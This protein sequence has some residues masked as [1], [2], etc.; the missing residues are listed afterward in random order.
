MKE[1]YIEYII[2]NLH[3]HIISYSAF[4][5]VTCSGKFRTNNANFI[6]R[7]THYPRPCWQHAQNSSNA[8]YVCRLPCPNNFTVLN[9]HVGTISTWH[10]PNWSRTQSN[11]QWPI[12]F[13]PSCFLCVAY[14]SCSVQP[15]NQFMSE[16][17]GKK[18]QF[19]LTVFL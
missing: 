4:N 5:R 7:L 3:D 1:N 14:V 2:W 18:A 17:R 12:L 15:I 11:S 10:A 6:C 16:C 13:C 8:Y 19:H 9:R